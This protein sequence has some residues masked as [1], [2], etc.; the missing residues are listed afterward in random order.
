M[1]IQFFVPPQ[2]LTRGTYPVGHCLQGSGILE[3]KNR[4]VLLT[5]QCENSQCWGEVQVRIGTG[6][7]SDI[8]HSNSSAPTITTNGGN[9]GDTVFC[10]PTVPYTRNISRRTLSSRFWHTGVQEPLCTADNTV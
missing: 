8:I 1:G 7:H 2:F 10:S 6:L 3:C 4:C 9:N 5:I